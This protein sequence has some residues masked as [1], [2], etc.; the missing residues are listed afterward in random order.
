MGHVRVR[1]DYHRRALRLELARG[2]G[3]LRLRQWLQR[4]LLIEVPLRHLLHLLHVLGVAVR[5]AILLRLVLVVVGVGIVMDG[6]VSLRGHLVVVL[7]LGLPAPRHVLAGHHGRPAR[8]CCL[9]SQSLARDRA[10]DV[11]G[12][13]GGGD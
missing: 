6:R 1:R 8:T 7:L 13:G 11:R 9:H 5:R 12:N 4:G 2:H 3:I 10:S